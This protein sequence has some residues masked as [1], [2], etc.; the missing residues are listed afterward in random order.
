MDNMTWTYSDQIKHFAEQMQNQV[1]V[2]MHTF[3]H[4]SKNKKTQNGV[5][6]TVST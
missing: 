3:F 2:S 5:N 6:N 1:N 4:L